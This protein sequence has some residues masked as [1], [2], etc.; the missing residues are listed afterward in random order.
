[1]KLPR[2]TDVPDAYSD[3]AH[4]EAAK[5]PRI[6]VDDSPEVYVEYALDAPSFVGGYYPVT[7]DEAADHLRRH[8]CRAWV[9]SNGTSVGELISTGTRCLRSWTKK[10]S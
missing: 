2:Q 7:P 8:S 4:S 9:I 1:M 5:L 3:K 6:W 10:S